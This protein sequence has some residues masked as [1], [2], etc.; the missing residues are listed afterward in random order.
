MN[1]FIVISNAKNLFLFSVLGTVQSG[2]GQGHVARARFEQV[3]DPL[4]DISGYCVSP[5]TQVVR[6]LWPML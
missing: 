6:H 1:Y 3:P 5:D 4:P 2:N